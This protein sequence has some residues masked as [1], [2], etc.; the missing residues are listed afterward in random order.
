M[1]TNGESINPVTYLVFLALAA[2]GF[3]AYHVGP[4]Y[5]DNLEARDAAG[6][7]FAVYA[8]SGEQVAHNKLL[9]RLNQRS[10]N[11]THFEVDRD[12]VE[13]EKPGYGLT[14]DNIS[15]NFDESTRTLTVRI[16][17]DRFVDFKPFKK[18]KSYHLVAEKTGVLA[19]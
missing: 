15:F 3:Y 7:A 17:Y 18:R 6:E 11:T 8:L 4:L 2:A 12:G 16:E 5:Y 14:D 13:S 10:P 1:R 9:T 19:K